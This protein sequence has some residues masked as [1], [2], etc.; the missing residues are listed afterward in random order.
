M[1]DLLKKL[2]DKIRNWLNDKCVKKTV[3]F[4]KENE[5]W[6]FDF[7][8]Y[9]FAKHNLLMVN[10]SDKLL[11]ML[12]NGKS[13]ISIDVYFSN[14]LLEDYKIGDTILLIQTHGSEL[15]GYYYDVIGNIPLVKEAYFCPVMF[16]KYGYYPKYIMIDM[17]S[18][19]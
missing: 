10:G 15:S 9:P 1:Q 7:P 12:A 5:L 2:T 3:S 17:N 18:I 11:D 8:N 14:E 16:F 13:K 19:N 6:Y 4:I